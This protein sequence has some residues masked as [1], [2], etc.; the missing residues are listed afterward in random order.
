MS[1]S[2]MKTM[3]VCFF[4]VRG[5]IHFEFVP[6]GQTVNQHLYVEILTRLRE[7]VRR[8]RPDLWKSGWMLHHDNASCHNALSVTQFLSKFNI[9]Q[10]EY[11]PYSPDLAPCDFFFFPKIKKSLKATRHASLVDMKKCAIAA[12]KS[13]TKEDFQGW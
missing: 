1:K 4:D 2:K 11:P 10:V 5:L 8:K 9:P 6:Q 7:S 12:S 13:V 3:L